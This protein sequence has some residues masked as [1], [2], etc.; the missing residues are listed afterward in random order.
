MKPASAARPSR[1]FRRSSKTLVGIALVVASVAG[2]GAIVSNFSKTRVIA[3]T[4]G[5]VAAGQSIDAS[6]VQ[7]LTVMDDPLF[8]N[9]A[10]PQDFVSSPISARSLGAG[11]LIPLGA[12]GSEVLSDDSVV[13]LELSIGEP[14][15]L[16]AGALTELWVAA[17]GAENSFL[18]PFVLSP[19]LRILRVSK[20]EGFAADTLTTRVDVLVPRRYL[21]GVIHALANRYFLHLSPLSGHSR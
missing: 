4:L 5:E 8:N 10:T 6:D 15:W 9:Y 7:A 20:D 3:I 19:Q 21:P 14:E 12:L 13:T 1:R 16:K 11:Q 18:A 2:V 17:P